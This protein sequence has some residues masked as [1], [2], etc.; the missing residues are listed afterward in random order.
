MGRG[1]RS[2][3][4]SARAGGVGRLRWLVGLG[5]LLVAAVAFYVLAIGTEDRGGPATR[6]VDRRPVNGP[7]LDEIDAESRA[8]MREILREA[9]EAD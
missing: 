4:G 1:G 6:S 7:A 3:R 8:R 9:D 5:A 2:A